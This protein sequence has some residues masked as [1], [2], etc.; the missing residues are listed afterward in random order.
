[1]NNNK[2]LPYE[3]DFLEI[4]P[5]IKK[6][7]KE[8]V[9]FGLLGLSISVVYVY[10]LKHKFEARTAIY[11]PHLYR[12]DI[13]SSDIK[14]GLE[15]Q[16]FKQWI[17][18]PGNLSKEILT[19]CGLSDLGGES[20]D[21]IYR[22]VLIPGVD[23][24][25]IVVS[26][27]SNNG[28]N[29][30]ACLGAGIKFIEEKYTATLKKNIAEMDQKIDQYKSCLSSIAGSQILRLDKNSM[31]TFLN[32]NRFNKCAYEMESLVGVINLTK[33]LNIT[34]VKPFSLVKLPFKP[35]ERSI[36]MAGSV[37]GILVGFGIGLIRLK[38]RNVISSTDA[39]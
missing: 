3:Y 9:I 7:I 11:L 21:Q 17:S 36:Y 14:L 29:A 23:Q 28:D 13:A 22:V 8:I 5:I 15:S 16:D 10:F 2:N 19:E 1:M 32:S 33:N 20:F 35:S 34:V 39:T 12:L 4:F 37:A 27:T 18:I 24:N 6:S 25:A 38:R 30:K 26:V 31:Y